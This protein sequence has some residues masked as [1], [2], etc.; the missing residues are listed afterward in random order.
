MVIS[1]IYSISRRNLAC[2]ALLR[3]KSPESTG[4]QSSSLA[5]ATIVGGC[6]LLGVQRLF[7][8]FPSGWPGL[9]LVLLRASVAVAV[10]LQAYGRLEVLPGLV[11]VALVVLCAI[12]CAGFLTP[13]IAL[14]AA[15]VHVVAAA[16][17]GMSDGGT[18]VVGILG[19]LA[20]AL[21]GPGAYSIDARL[22]GR[23]LIELPEWKD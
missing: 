4:R 7:S 14:C 17:L 9:G 15:A 16:S 13:M 20:L 8:T 21:L 22:F 19:A 12:L 5:Y 23:R 1:R 6:T 3:R 11:L 10:L 2:S 18:T